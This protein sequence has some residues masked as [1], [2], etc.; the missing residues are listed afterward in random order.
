MRFLHNFLTN[1]PSRGRPLRPSLTCHDD[2]DLA[3]EACDALKHYTDVEFIGALRARFF[4]TEMNFIAKSKKLF[5]S[6]AEKR[7]L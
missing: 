6:A 2:K 1:L 7:D 3:D 4:A 5:K